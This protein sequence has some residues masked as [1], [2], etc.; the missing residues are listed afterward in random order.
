MKVWFPPPFRRVSCVLIRV[1]CRLKRGA[2]GPSGATGPPR[3][4]VVG[5]KAGL[6]V[7]AQ[8]KLDLPVGSQSDGFSDGAREPPEGT[9]RGGRKRLA[10]LHRIGRP[11]IRRQRTGKRADRIREVAL[12]EDVE[13]FNSE[14]DVLLP[15]SDPEMLCRNKVG[16]YEA[17]AVNRTT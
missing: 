13:R 14:L 4:S 2:A 10:W 16:L 8:R 11:G 3:R 7:Q 5:A 9:C 6:E 15:A 17:R 12:V 1:T